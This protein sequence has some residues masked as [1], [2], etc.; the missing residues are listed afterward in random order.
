M[1]RRTKRRLIVLGIVGGVI[2]A[3]GVGGQAV[4]KV[5]RDRLAEASLAEGLAAYEQGDYPVARRKLVTHL[6]IKGP[7]AEAL[8]AL[9]DS[10]R[11]LIEP[12][13]KHLFAA[14]SYLEQAVLLD[15]ENDTAREIL[16]ELYGQLGNWQELAEVAEALLE[17][18]PTNARFAT[19]R[20]EAHLQRGANDDA[21]AAATEFVDAQG[22]SIESHLEMLRV[23]R[24]IGRNAR[25][26]RQ[27]LEDVVAQQHAGTTSLAVLRATVDFDAGRTSEALR[28]LVDAAESGPTEGSGAR[29][30]LQA[31]EQVAARTGD[32]D[33]Y[34]Q[35]QGWLLRWLED[36]SM[37]PYL[38][39]IAAGRAWRDR[40]PQAAVDH[41][42]RAIGSEPESEAVFAWGALGAIELG[43][44]YAEQVATLREAFESSVTTET[45]DR[46]QRWRLVM[47]AAQRRVSG[48][49]TDDQPLLAN[50]LGVNSPIG[51]DAVAV[52]YDAIGDIDRRDT[53][54][55]VDRLAGLSQQP[56][57]RRARFALL[58]LLISEDRSLDARAVLQRD[59]RLL[60]L[61]GSA[62]L[63]GELIARLAETTDT[64]GSQ[65][66]QAID[67]MLDVAPENPVALAA[68]GRFTV[69]QGDHEAAKGIARR[70]IEVDASQAATS[71]VRF[72][73]ALQPIDATLARAIV[74]RVAE[75]A[76]DPLQVAA[77]SAGLAV[78]GDPTAA[79]AFMTE[80]LAQAED[81]ADVRWSL[82]RIQMANAIS[83]DQSLDSLE[84]ISSAS[85]ESR[86]VQLEILSG[87]TIW[88]DLDRAGQVVA[89]L[90]E[91]QG[92]SGIEWR[93][94][95]AR[96]LLEQDAS[97]E[98]ASTA[99]S[100]L[101]VVFEN[102]RGKRDTRA[103]LLAAQ[104]FARTGP[105]ESE[106]EALENA[107]DG[108]EPL[109]ALPRLIDRLQRT[110][111]SNEAATRLRQFVDAGDV[112]PR[113]REARWQLLSQQG[114]FDLASRDLAALADAGV[115]EF[116][117][118]AGV[119]SRPPDSSTPLRDDEIAAL[120]AD[121]D[122]EDEIHAA[123]LLAR[124]GRV[125]DGLSRL[126]A[127]PAESDAGKR[128][129]VVARFLNEHGQGE[130]A[131]EQLVLAAQAS[132]DPDFWQEAATLHI[133]KGEFQEASA[134]L[135]QAIA[136][137]PGNAALAS[138]RE[139]LSDEM[140]P[141]DRMARVTASAAD[142]TNAPEA[143]LAVGEVA[144]A[145]LSG[146]IDLA[147]T[148][149]RLDRLSEERASFYSL[150]PM[151]VSAYE[152]LG[153]TDVA[154]RRARDAVAALPNDAR[155]ARDAT[156]VLLRHS[157]FEEAAAMAD[158]W[159]S[160]AS[161]SD[162]QARAE[163]SL[164][165]AEF[166][167]SNFGR[168]ISLL[169]PQTERMLSAWQ[170]N[171]LPLQCLAE[172]LAREDRM[173]EAGTLLDQLVAADGGWA[174]LK[175]SLA[176]IAANTAE[177]ISRGRMWL[178]SVAPQLK[179]SQS[180]VVAI[181]SSW[182]SLHTASGDEQ[183]ARE[184]IACI[185]PALDTPID[186]WQ[187]R[188]VYATALE[189]TGQPADAVNEYEQAMRIAG[190][191]IPALINNAAWLLTRSLDD[192]ERAIEF[193][194]EA[195]QLAETQPTAPVNLATFR[196][197]LGVALLA[198]GQGAEALQAFDQGL[199][200]QDTPSLRLGRIESLVA[201]NR[202]DE[203]RREFSLI[204]PTD[205]WTETNT[206]RY[207]ELQSLLG[208]G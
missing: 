204:S 79:R 139:S 78:L 141:F 104:A 59:Q 96:R 89:R 12:N 45:R 56:S 166:Y 185:E 19:H 140:S 13:A 99:A 46:A 167:R 55:A 107:A 10:Q 57:W 125:D 149:A 69:S 51:V 144:K 74:D 191:R 86:Q 174:Q 9:G 142:R 187:L 17:R 8:T 40:D 115:P 158:R 198:S 50:E 43:P 102:E 157:R 101:S 147:Q 85:T 68:A 82:A 76:T 171:A 34:I 110:G 116:I 122:P 186:S 188:A 154:I 195:V 64:A 189:A 27:Y 156:E 31:V 94:F 4:R 71:A 109:L 97:V 44:D 16:L 75:T 70:L 184:A 42:L 80:R 11:F 47:D 38:S 29:M 7:E 67:E 173:E 131:I 6:R 41:A 203:A 126:Q 103:L 72:A 177:N 93:V 65:F 169:Q 98:A 73:A 182:M 179:D 202:T 30:L 92:E 83:D 196:H 194:R 28:L 90:R 207:S 180:G 161:E 91:A 160:L 54:G 49:T 62:Q 61:P 35:S 120:E 95:E 39:E 136:E 138:F 112:Q 100:Y 159:R 137:L 183:F 81:P 135:D 63:Y 200:S 201:L 21:L 164:G 5:Q 152:Q 113:I 172:A 1:N 153:Q 114:L 32:W 124:V 3:A 105:V 22:G 168:S 143:N 33:L 199:A 119:A 24:R 14:K 130:R 176:G 162:E 87:S 53:R 106:I 23:F 117:L 181:A 192:H 178:E 132:G 128:E 127:L 88:T 25:E 150:W 36:D 146:E 66:G 205:R 190:E 26:Q 121:L 145:Y 58:S 15:P 197:T 108:D 37:T 111:R 165:V 52:Y 123:R 133:E 118:R 193:A 129:V 170:Q 151:I 134:L 2:I 155:P 20:I 60:E 48:T 84:Q 163:I 148:V 77:A 18:D 206:K 175:A 208:A